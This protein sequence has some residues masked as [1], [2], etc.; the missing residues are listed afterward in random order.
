MR[1]KVPGPPEFEWIAHDHGKLISGPNPPAS[2]L[3]VFALH[4][5]FGEVARRVVASQLTDETAKMS[6]EAGFLQRR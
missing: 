1:D 4:S 5:R 6:G 2:D 3:E